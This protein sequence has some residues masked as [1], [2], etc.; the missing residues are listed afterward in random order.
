VILKS[1]KNNGFSVKSPLSFIC[2]LAET[3]IGFFNEISGSSLQPRLVKKPGIQIGIQ[4]PRRMFK[5]PLV[6]IIDVLE[7][8]DI[9][10]RPV[11]VRE[12]LEM[13]IVFLDELG[14]QFDFRHSYSRSTSIDQGQ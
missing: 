7:D 8:C 11:P 13:D 14:G 4:I 12:P 10:R 6:G 3:G 5:S 9:L 1:K 2:T